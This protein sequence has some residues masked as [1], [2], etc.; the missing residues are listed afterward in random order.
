MTRPGTWSRF[1]AGLLAI[2]FSTFVQRAS[3]TRRRTRRLA[4]LAATGI[5]AVALAPPPVRAAE[6]LAEGAT[7]RAEFAQVEGGWHAGTLRRMQDQCW[8]VFLNKATHDGYTLIALVAATR[9][10]VTHDDQWVD[11]P[12]AATLKDQPAGCLEEGSD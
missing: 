5:A 3:E 6:L 2:A 4:I 9:V 11:T 1:A 10:Q 7:V 12:F 8:M